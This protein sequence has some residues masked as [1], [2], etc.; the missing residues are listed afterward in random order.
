MVT[1]KTD[2]TKTRVDR[3][4][5]L[6]S[7]PGL[8]TVNNI[9]DACNESFQKLE[10]YFN[11]SSEYCTIEIVLDPRFKLDFFDDS[12]KS[13]QENEIQKKETWDAV[14]DVFQQKYY[15]DEQENG[16]VNVKSC[17]EAPRSLV[18]KKL[19]PAPHGDELQTYLL[20]LRRINDTSDP[21]NWW[22][23][24]SEQ[25]PQL[26]LMARDYLSIPGTSTSSE[27][28]FSGGI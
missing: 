7:N 17:T 12:S 9:I 14:K 28:A 2:R 18:F 27:R 10:N 4:M 1:Y 26:A 8:E 16:G 3:N 15:A 11:I 23:V 21:L 19:K 22:K 20:E 13:T 24:N 25:L 6:Q 5:K